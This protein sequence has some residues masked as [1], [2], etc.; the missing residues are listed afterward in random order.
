MKNYCSTINAGLYMTHFIWTDWVKDFYI[1]ILIFNIVQFFPFLNHNIFSLILDKVDFNSRISSFFSNYLINRKTQYTWNNFVS[2]FLRADI[3][4]GQGS[5]LS[6]I[7]SILYIA[8]IFHIFKKRT[9]ILL[10]LIS[11]FTLSF[12]DNSFFIS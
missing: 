6:P 11:I 1:S 8:L 5:A 10:S 3:S 4:I 9:Q 12:V 7:L 2:P